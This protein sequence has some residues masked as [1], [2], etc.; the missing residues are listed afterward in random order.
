MAYATR[1]QLTQLAIPAAALT[2]VSTADQDAALEAASDLADGY[3]RSRYALPLTAWEDDLRRAVCGIAAYDL[4]TRRGFRPEDSGENVRLRYEDA[5]RW[6]KGVADGSI[7]P[8]ITDST[9]TEEE[10]GLQ[11]DTEA[12]R[13]W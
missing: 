13:G 10:G 5:V 11:V 12:R 2:G 3:L 4:L 7:S 9:P 8:S 1:T 6:L